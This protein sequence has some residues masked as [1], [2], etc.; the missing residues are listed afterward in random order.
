MPRARSLLGVLVGV[1]LAATP[2]SARAQVEPSAAGDEAPRGDAEGASSSPAAAAPASS[3]PASARPAAA[4][5]SDES[6]AARLE[7]LVEL[8]GRY[9]EEAR[10]FRE[11]VR[12]ISERKYKERRAAIEANYDKALAPVLDAERRFRL[13]AIAAFER[14]LERHPDNPRYTPD[15][16]FRLAELYFEKYDDEY[17]VAM[18]AF[19]DEYQKWY[20]ADGEGEPPS[21]PPQRFDRTIALYQELIER[22]PS[23]RLLDGA[24][25]LLGYTLNMQGE[26]EEGMLAWRTLVDR[27]PNSRFY[28]EVWFRI[29][30]YH[31]DEEEWPEAVAAF[32]KVVPETESPY[33]DKGLYKLAWTYYLTNRFEDG[34]DRFFELLDYSYAKKAESDGEGVG[35]VLEDESLQYVAISFSDDNWVRPDAY[36]RLISGDSLDDEFADIETDYV[37]FAIDYFQKVGKKP[38]ERDVMARLGDILFKQSK[39]RQ[40]VLALKHAISLDPL[41]R[42]APKLQ[43]LIV[44]AYER[45]RQFDEASAERDL[46]VAN[47]SEGSE[48]AKAHHDDSEARREATELARVSLYKAAIYYHTQAN[49]YFEDGKQDLGVT[50]FEA[51]SAAYRDYLSQYP[52]DKQAYELLFYLAE[53][54]YYSLHFERAAETYEKVR[55]STAGRAYQVD[56]A[57]NV[58]YSLE[59]IIA[60]KV[61]DGELPEKDPFKKSEEEAEQAAE[62]E[63]AAGEAA[64][65]VAAAPED[66]APLRLR[67]VSAID[68]LLEVKADDEVAPSFAYSAAAIFYAHGHFEEAMKR[69]EAIVQLYPQHEAARFAANLILDR[70]LA[71]QDW[72]RAAEYASRFQRTVT[73]GDSAVFAKIEGGAK[74]KIATQVLDEGAKDIEEGRIAEGIA[75]LEEGANSYLTLVEEDPQREFADLMVYNA[76]VSLERAR[77]PARAAQLY[78]RVY[79]EYPESTYAAQAMFNVASKSEQAFDFDKAVTTYLD[80]VKRYPQSERR[81]DAQINAALALEGQQKYERAAAEFQRFA[82]LFPERPEAP[83]VFFRSAIVHR[84][85]GNSGDEIRALRDFISR[86]RSSA[87]QV[88]RVVEAYARLGD[89]ERERAEK[90]KQARDKKRLNDAADTAYKQAIQEFQRA[91]GSQTAAYFAAK[92]SF[93][94]AEREFDDYVRTRID[95]N[96]GRGQGKQLADKAQRLEEVRKT[97]ESVIT[98]YRQADWSLAALFRIGAL[99]DDLQRKIIDAPCP[100]DIRRIDPIACDEYRVVL[101]DQA[102]AVEEKAVEA[103]RVAY[104][105]AREL[106]VSNE[107]TKRTLEA[108]NRLRQADFPIDKEPI[109][110]PSLG[111]VYDLGFVLPDGGAH[112]LQRLGAGGGG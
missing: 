10:D 94:L 101:E 112:E 60:Q 93:H 58:V 13:D 26:S 77:R 84:Q 40:A 44:Q 42:E 105:R 2:V 27:Y 76:A 36:R 47:Y 15:A 38:Y 86:Y 69:F 102:Y 19:R 21:E 61:A 55:D 32:L 68:K 96:T 4:P 39:N 88:P 45:E 34:V 87:P 49:K 16:M 35:S 111:E 81:A 67:Y 80:L 24:Y 37:R 43:D 98:T 56:A 33:Y 71:Q 66:I 70:L 51:A 79:Q 23:Y 50:A 53:T 82:T 59:K 92:A 97:Y 100:A 30:D 54:Y 31:F 95:S 83:E 109:E 110:V 63:A 41:H 57:R 52:H 46:L 20:D 3:T 8:V 48:W 6:D 17:Q 78:E 9:E 107:W 72:Q 106:K 103:Y 73:S 85:R 12:R 28:A 29:G 5:M 99:Y 14:F 22:F 65:A 108:L 1:A 64:S 89:I 62:A 7:A 91:R 18:R 25:Y 75:K 90:A 74:F 104:E 11:Q